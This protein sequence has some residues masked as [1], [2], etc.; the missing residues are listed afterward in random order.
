MVIDFSVYSPECSEHAITSL[1]CKLQHRRNDA[2][3]VNQKH[4]ARFSINLIY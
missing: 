3:F 1:T 4:V 2:I